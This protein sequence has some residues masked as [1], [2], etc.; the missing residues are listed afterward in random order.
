MLKFSLMTTSYIIKTRRF[1]FRGSRLPS[2]HSLGAYSFT[3]LDLGIVLGLLRPHGINVL[4]V[5]IVTNSTV[6]CLRNRAMI[7]MAKKL[8]H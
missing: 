1:I 7:S 3:H 8:I 2:L 5:E 6:R 4:V